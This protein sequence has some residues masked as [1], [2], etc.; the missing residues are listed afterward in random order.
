M[1]ANVSAQ[2]FWAGAISA[3]VGKAIQP[4]RIESGG[5]D[6]TLFSFESKRVA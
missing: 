6:W 3:F 5:E 1:Q 2:H 4:V